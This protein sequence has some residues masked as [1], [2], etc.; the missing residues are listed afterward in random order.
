V[1]IYALK[2]TKNATQVYWV[3]RITIAVV[4]NFVNYAEVTVRSA[5]KAEL[6]R[7]TIFKKF[8]YQIRCHSY[9]L[10][11]ATRIHHVV[12][13][14][15]S[16]P[17]GSSVETLSTQPVNKN[18][19]APANRRIVQPVRRCQMVPPVWREVS[20]AL[21]NAYHIARHKAYRVVCVIKVCIKT[22]LNTIC[23]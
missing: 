16:C 3:P 6:G 14:V 4:I 23:S 12:K 9:F 22:S 15:S 1:V 19:D 8:S 18:L 11:T 17:L 20:A 5:G 2:R 7:D 13:H 10:L 21:E